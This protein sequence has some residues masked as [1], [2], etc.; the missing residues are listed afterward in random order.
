MP[1]TATV[2]RRSREAGF[3]TYAFLAGVGVVFLVGVAATFLLPHGSS[4]NPRAAWRNAPTEI[5]LRAG[6]I[7]LAPNDEDNC[8]QFSFDNQSGQLQDKG[9]LPCGG[10]PTAR[11]D[12]RRQFQ[13]IRDGFTK[14]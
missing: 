13:V 10:S 12:V 14:R 7:Q 1:K 8:R 5:E 6:T 11:V 3:L 9:L 2:N 4:F